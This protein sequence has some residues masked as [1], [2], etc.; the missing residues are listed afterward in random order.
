MTPRVLAREFEAAELRSVDTY[1]ENVT[2]AYNVARCYAMVRSK[3]G[4]PPLS[5]LL[6]EVKTKRD[7]G[8]QSAGSMRHAVEMLSQMSGI[9]M[10]RKGQ[11]VQK[12]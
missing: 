9:P 12:P 11:W 3:K 6:D 8:P 4:M 5:Q 2:L 7:D 1:R 10:H